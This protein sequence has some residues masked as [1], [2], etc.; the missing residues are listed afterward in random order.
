[1]CAQF[2]SSANRNTTGSVKLKLFKGVAQVV[3]RA[4]EYGLYD[5]NMISYNEEHTFD[6]SDA[7]G[8]IS[9]WGLPTRSA[10]TQSKK[11]KS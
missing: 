8:F 6:Q 11:V 5:K 3:G 1:M 10:N 4:S 9:L 7:V 2:I